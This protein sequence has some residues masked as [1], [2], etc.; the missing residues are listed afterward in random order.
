MLTPEALPTRDVSCM[1][2]PD[3]ILCISVVGHHNLNVWQQ[4]FGILVKHQRRQTEENVFS[5]RPRRSAV[6]FTVCAYRFNC[7]QKFITVD[8]VLRAA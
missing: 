1:K 8:G 3:N 6:S 5:V 7:W 2:L 4:G